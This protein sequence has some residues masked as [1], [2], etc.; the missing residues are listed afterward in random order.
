MVRLRAIFTTL[1]IINEMKKILAAAIC[2]QFLFASGASKNP[3]IELTRSAAVEFALNN[4]LDLKAVQEGIAAAKGRARQSGRM[5]NPVISAEYG[6]DTIFSNEGEYAVR[7]EIAQKF[8]LFG[9]LSKE[10]DVGNIDIKLAELEYEEARR[11]LALQVETAYIYVLEK[12][13]TGGAKREML[14][15]AKE[16]EKALKSAVLSAER[17][18]LEA[19]RAQSE[20]A[21]LQIEI[22]R[23][24]V[25]IETAM[26]QLK[27]LLG[28]PPDAVL[29]LSDK[30]EE[31]PP[32]SEKFSQQVLESRP[33]W[34][35]YSIAVQSANAQIA[36]IKAGRFEDIEI[37]VF[38]EAGTTVDE[39]I[40]KKPEKTMGLSV[41]IP[42]PLNSFDGSIDEKLSLRRKAEILSAAKENQIRGEIAVYRTR[43]EKYLQILHTQKSEAEKFSNEIY[44]EYLDAR[45]HAQADITDVFGAWQ[46]HLQLKLSRISL[47]AEQAKNSIS[48]KYALGIGVKNE[49]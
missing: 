36:L 40:G 30:L 8:P 7:A 29:K 12:V 39:P 26:S 31:I 1:K 48:L 13:S 42:L 35:M 41:S 11:I 15:A 17:S 37:G 32:S 33:D 27:T 3:V 23:D 9:R 43:A 19:K 18:P 44:A 38:F 6:N 14:K 34:R 47:V 5:E 24:E 28:L 4:N 16:F 46:T 2:L 25:E 22:M 10:R 21:N 20:S 49:K 45:K